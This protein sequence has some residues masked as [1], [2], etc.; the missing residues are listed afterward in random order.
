MRLQP[1]Q[2]LCVTSME[3]P[4]GRA[5]ERS[6]ETLKTRLAH[7]WCVRFEA[8]FRIYPASVFGLPD[9]DTKVLPGT[10]GRT[11]NVTH[12]PIDSTSLDKVGWGSMP[13][14][15]REEDAIKA[16]FDLGEVHV[17]LKD[18]YATLTFEAVDF[19]QAAL[20]G[21]AVMHDF[22]RRLTMLMSVIFHYRRLRLK[23]DSGESIPWFPPARFHA[24]LYSLPQLQAEIDRART[25]CELN[26]AVFEK[27]IL[28]LE[29]AK[30]IGDRMFE[31]T[32]G[33]DEHYSLLVADSLLSY[34]K[35][36]TTVVGDKSKGEDPRSRCETLGLPASYYD[37]KV[38]PVRRARNDYDI[39]HYDLE[40][41]RVRQAE[42]LVKGVHETATE[43]L[44]AYA[45]YL[46]AGGRSFVG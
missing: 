8:L 43:V 23:S 13:E 39:A 41:E 1:I 2:T 27:A 33:F 34:W 24:T 20:R 17:E 18:N 29:H 45:A 6:E 26:D 46:K 30:L 32:Q 14:Y 16:S 7:S 28:Y 25:L 3:R 19:S 42:Q 15:R 22:L 4:M 21:C 35:A 36:I 9:G 10:P 44:L 37:Q 11:F 40:K 5:S 31:W 12:D 38:D